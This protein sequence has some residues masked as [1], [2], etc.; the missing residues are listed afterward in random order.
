MT[1]I[2]K[3]VLRGLESSQL[4]AIQ[5]HNHRIVRQIG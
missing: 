1:T 2:Q 3:A 4:F 5:R